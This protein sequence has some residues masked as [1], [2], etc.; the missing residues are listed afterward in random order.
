MQQGTRRWRGAFTYVAELDDAGRFRRV[1]VY[2][3]D[4]IEQARARFA[5][6]AL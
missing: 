2:D 3:V 5:E 1:D 6:I 4:Q